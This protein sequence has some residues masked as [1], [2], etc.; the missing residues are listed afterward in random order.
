MVNLSNCC[1]AIAP[2]FNLVLVY[3]ARMS[4]V[5]MGHTLHL[6]LHAQI[7]NYGPISAM[8]DFFLPR[9]RPEKVYKVQYE[10]QRNVGT[11][12][13]TPFLNIRMFSPPKIPFLLPGVSLLFDPEK[14][15]Q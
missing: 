8:I 9:H 4:K 14:R 5:G 6:F 10:A 15:L 2:A 1:N 3:F 13:N 12:S 7:R 11:C